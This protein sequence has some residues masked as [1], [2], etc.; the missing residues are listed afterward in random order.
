[1]K[2]VEKRPAPQY[3]DKEQTHLGCFRHSFTEYLALFVKQGSTPRQL[4]SNGSNQ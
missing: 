1:M 3:L 2:C 4:S